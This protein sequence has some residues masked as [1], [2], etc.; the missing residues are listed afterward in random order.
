[1]SDE[2][3][4]FDFSIEAFLGLNTDNLYTIVNALPILAQLRLCLLKNQLLSTI[5]RDVLRNYDS[6][7]IVIG[8]RNLA[9]DSAFS[10]PHS[11]EMAYIQDTASRRTLYLKKSAWTPPMA[12]MIVETFTSVRSLM[13]SVNEYKMPKPSEI[14]QPIANPHEPDLPLALL[15]AGLRSNLVTF[16]F[17]FTSPNVGSAYCL[18]L[19]L[20]RFCSAT[21]QHLCIDGRFV[22]T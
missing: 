13:V 20:I 5:S 12:K 9:L 17:H 16:N 10:I 1:L 2:F 19:I 6:L 11:G 22:R 21:L 14:V 15:L 7:G 4:L 18:L 8:N 3:L